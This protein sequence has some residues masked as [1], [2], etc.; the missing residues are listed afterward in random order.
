MRERKIEGERKGCYKKFIQDPDP[1]T[2]FLKS[3]IRIRKKS[4]RI[5]NSVRGAVTDRKSVTERVKNALGNED[6][7]SIVKGEQDEHRV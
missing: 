1:E 7:F 5:H 4:F 3:R 2:N 6:R